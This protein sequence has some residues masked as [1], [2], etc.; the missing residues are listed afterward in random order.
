MANGS[1]SPIK[2]SKGAIIGYNTSPEA[3][4]SHYSD[5]HQKV[6]VRPI[7]IKSEPNRALFDFKPKI[8][9]PYEY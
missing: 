8:K 1:I 2:N 6:D 3:T 7:E 9:S 5:F 4:Q